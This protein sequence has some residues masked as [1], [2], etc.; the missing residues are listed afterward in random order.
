MF[1]N[2]VDVCMVE[3]A[4]GMEQD[5]DNL[6]NHMKSAFGSSWKE[7]LSDGPL[8]EGS[9]DNGSPA[10]LIISTSALRSLELLR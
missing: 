7:V 4:E 9:V 8:E 2:S 1:E 3:L 10:L 5:I 6:S